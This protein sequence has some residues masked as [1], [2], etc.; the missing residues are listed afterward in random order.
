MKTPGSGGRRPNRLALEKSPYLLQHAHNPVHWFPWGAEAFDKARSED[1]PIFLSVGYSTCHWCHVMERE[2]FENAEVAAVLNDHFVSIKLDREERPD[3]DEIYMKALT[4]VMGQSGGWPMSM[5]LTPELKPFYG[6]TYFPAVSGYGRPGFK[7]LLLQLADAWKNKRQEILH[8]SGHIT[9]MLTKPVPSSVVGE[10][11]VTL[12]QD[13]IKDFELRFDF[14]TGGFGSAPKFPQPSLLSFLLRH[15]ARTGNQ[16]AL[17]MVELQLTSMATGGIYDHLGGGFSRYSVDDRWLV[18]HFEKML[19]DNAQLLR[20]YTEAYQVTKNR[21]YLQIIQ[22]TGRYVLREMTSANGGFYSAQ[23]ADSEG[24]EGRYY[25]WP[26]DE[27][28]QALGADASLFSEV[29]GVTESGNW[30]DPHHDTAGLNVLH[31]AR[32]PDDVAREKNI[33]VSVLLEKLALAKSKLLRLRSERVHPG[34]DDKVITSWNGLMISGLALAGRAIGEATFIEGARRSAEFILSSLYRDEKLLRRW[35]DNDVVGD[36]ILEDYAYLAAG[37]IDLYEATFEERWLVVARRLMNVA[38]EQFFD[39]ADGGFFTTIAGCPDLIARTKDLDDG[40]MPSASAITA[41]NCLRLGRIFSDER[42]SDCAERA[43]R[44]VVGIMKM[45]PSAVPNMLIAVDFILG[46]T[47]EVVLVGDALEMK[48]LLDSSFLPR[49]IVLKAPSDLIPT[50]AGKTQLGGEPTA[51]VCESFVCQ[52]PIT[53]IFEL[54][55]LMRT[56]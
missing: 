8:S 36:G 49:T 41:L 47:G 26:K 46:P 9:E 20:V 25:V 42:L 5:W 37:L 7:S 52:Q 22:E 18:P 17:R 45:H 38:I 23:D 21:S 39:S 56:K 10:L 12:I 11:D 24:V 15:H 50:V 34:L 35:R 16:S 19:Y 27:I 4:Q 3:V 55:E 6:G 31:L 2:S 54:Q 32:S 53:N 33:E 13:A 40:A 1:K 14:S 48:K 43:G 30:S 28:E 51:Y 29:Y 44:A